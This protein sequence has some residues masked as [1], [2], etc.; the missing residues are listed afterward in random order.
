MLGGYN[1]E[2][3]INLLNDEEVGDTAVEALSHTLL[4]F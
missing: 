2:P 1:V 4:I 3:L